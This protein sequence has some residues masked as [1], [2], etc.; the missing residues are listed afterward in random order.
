MKIEL[1]RLDDAYHM[2][3]INEEGQTTETDGSPAIG[4]HNKAMRPM[5]MLL[6]SMGACSSIDI[7][8]LLNKQR[9][10]LDDIKIS[11]NGDREEG[12]VPSLFTAIQVHYRLY[13]DLDEKKMHEAGQYLLGEND[14][15]SFRAAHCQSLSPC[16]NMMHLN[17]TRHGDYVVIDIKA[18]AFV[19]HMVRNITGSLIKVGRGEEKPEWIKS[20]LEAKDR[21]LAGATAKAEGLYLVDVDYPEEFGLPRV[22]IGPLFLPDNLN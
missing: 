14:F 15:S 21:K 6:S 9:Q 19:H 2:Q 10:K 8:H 1:T 11:L 12:K 4:G 5:Q 13:G 18:N 20:L 3:A 22:P 16:R 7:I 17:V